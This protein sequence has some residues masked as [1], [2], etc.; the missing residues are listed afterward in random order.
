MLTIKKDLFSFKNTF[1]LL[2]N[3]FRFCCL[4]VF[5]YQFIEI[6]NNYLSFPIEIKLNISDENAID[7]PSVTFCLSKSKSWNKKNS[8]DFDSY[9]S[10]KKS[11]LLNSSGDE[12][13]NY[14]FNQIFDQSIDLSSAIDCSVALIVNENKF[15]NKCEKI[16]RNSKFIS[17]NS[18]YGKCFTYFNI[19]YK[20]NISMNYKMDKSSFI[21]FDLSLEKFTEFLISPEYKILDTIYLS[22]HS[23]QSKFSDSFFI[24][25]EI[26]FQKY[27]LFNYKFSRNYLNSLDWPYQTNCIDFEVFNE[28]EPSF[29]DCVNSCILDR[30]MKRFKCFHPENNLGIDVVLNEKTEKMR[31]CVN[32]TKNESLLRNL[33]K[34]C[35]RN[36]RENCIT[37][38]TSF[39]LFSEEEKKNS[40]TT[41]KLQITN[42]PI[43]EYSMYSKLSLV[44][45]AS[46]L[47]SIISMW[48]GFSVIDLHKLFEQL[49]II[50]IYISEKFNFI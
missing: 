49:L 6:T 44:N 4:I 26:N 27:K 30:M 19:N 36:C 14:T 24:P 31:L 5:I 37:E 45:Y 25:I 28:K 13:N 50:L 1:F 32:Y 9:S 10:I 35:L 29:L 22:V 33:T 11:E 41:I 3:I 47:G 15:Y 46:N 48:F 43:Y 16:G 8:T 40:K 18:H 12:D 39:Y 21:E 34:K 20:T 38:Y 42:N 17:S 2:K 7:L 23:S